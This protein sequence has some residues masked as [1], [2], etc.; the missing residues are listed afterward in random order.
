MSLHMF[1]QETIDCRHT[2]LN[3]AFVQGEA[4]GQC[5]IQCR[6]TQ[7]Y[8]AQKYHAVRP[9]RQVRRVQ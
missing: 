8:F 4:S 6:N 7:P 1:E 5:P 9:S 2:T 3:T